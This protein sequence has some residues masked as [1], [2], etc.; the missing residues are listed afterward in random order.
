MNA[1]RKQLIT[2][3]QHIP[4]SRLQ[5]IFDVIHLFRLG[6]DTDKPV[7]I[8]QFAGAWADMDD[9]AFADWDTE[10]RERRRQAFSRRGPR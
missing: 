10:W 6:L 7:N 4:D 8:R 5:E 1:L 2:E 3:I 9:T